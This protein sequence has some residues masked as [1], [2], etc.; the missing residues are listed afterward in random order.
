MKFLFRL[1]LEGN[2]SLKSWGFQFKFNSLHRATSTFWE[3]SNSRLDTFLLFINR[4]FTEAG[5]RLISLAP[6]FFLFLL[7]LPFMA[8]NV[9]NIRLVPASVIYSSVLL[10]YFPVISV[11]SYVFKSIIGSFPVNSIIRSVIACG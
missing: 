5:V 6:F 1:F 2:E 7:S 4:Q 9:V 10:I 3:S 8:C 11:N